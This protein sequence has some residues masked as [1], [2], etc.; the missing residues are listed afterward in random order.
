MEV[1][2]VLFEEAMYLMTGVNTKC[3][4]IEKWI[5]LIKYML[6]PHP[7]LMISLF[8]YVYSTSFEPSTAFPSWQPLHSY[9]HPT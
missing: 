2:G 1:E 8:I 4:T 7:D 5:T 3:A 9:Y 6:I